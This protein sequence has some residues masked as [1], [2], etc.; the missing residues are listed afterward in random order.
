MYDCTDYGR[1]MFFFVNLS[2]RGLYDIRTFAPRSMRLFAHSL[3]QPKLAP[4]ALAPAL[5]P[6]RAAMTGA[7]PRCS[8]VSARAGP[9]ATL[10]LLV[11]V[12]VRLG[13]A[14]D[15]ALLEDALQDDVVVVRAE[16]FPKVT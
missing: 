7:W 11:A 10:E 14:A 5:A 3:P 16:A 13:A 6:T 12:R 2:V 4:S 15:L 8:S 9:R 1:N